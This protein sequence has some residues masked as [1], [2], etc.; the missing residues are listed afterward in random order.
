MATCGLG[1]VNY[2]DWLETL[3]VREQAGYDSWLV[4]DVFPSRTDPVQTLST[5]YRTIIYA[6]KLLDKFGRQHLWEMIQK[7]DVIG[8]YDEFQ[9]IMISV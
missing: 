9:K 4:S 2:W 1:T 6:E 5:S 3:I 8:I 7:G